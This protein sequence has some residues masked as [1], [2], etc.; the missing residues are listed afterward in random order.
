MLRALTRLPTSLKTS[1]DWVSCATPSHAPSSA[2]RITP[3]NTLLRSFQRTKKYTPKGN[4]SP[5][6]GNRQF[7][8][9]KG[10]AKYGKKDAR[11]VWTMTKLPPYSTLDGLDTF[12]LKPYVEWTAAAAAKAKR[13]AG[14][15]TEV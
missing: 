11:A 13:P 9:G 2:Q 3:P 14:S 15:S 8:K 6:R 1:A 7:Y 12:E 4:F 5:K 10:D